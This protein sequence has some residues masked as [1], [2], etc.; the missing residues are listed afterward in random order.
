MAVKVKV[1]GRRWIRCD[2][3]ACV[4]GWVDVVIGSDKGSLLCVCGYA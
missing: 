4:V 2:G 1:E 3:G